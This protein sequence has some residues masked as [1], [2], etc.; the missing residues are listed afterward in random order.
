MKVTD[1]FFDNDLY[2]FGLWRVVLVVLHLGN[3]VFKILDHLQTLL[4]QIL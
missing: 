2:V 4:L 1:Y 3:L